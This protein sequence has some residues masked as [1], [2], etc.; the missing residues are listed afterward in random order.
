MNKLSK[1]DIKLVREAIKRIVKE[2]G[3]ILIRLGRE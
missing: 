2:Y 3:G 1:K